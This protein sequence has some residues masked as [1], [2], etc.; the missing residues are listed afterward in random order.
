MCGMP[1]NISK[2]ALTRTTSPSQP[3]R[4]VSVVKVFFK[5]RSWLRRA[6]ALTP[7]SDF[8]SKRRHCAR[9]EE[10]CRASPVMWKFFREAGISSL[11][12]VA[13]VPHEFENFRTWCSVKHCPHPFG[14]RSYVCVTCDAEVYRGAGISSFC[15]VASVPHEFENF[16]TWCSTLPEV[17]LFARKESQ[18]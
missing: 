1:P 2:P 5:V 8:R 3:V 15:T 18:S 7:R 11:Y 13:P 9:H 12:T 6:R 14:M 17:V 4:K 16:R 10:L